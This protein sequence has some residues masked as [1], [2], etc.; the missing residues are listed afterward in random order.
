[1]KIVRI[2]IIVE[3]VCITLLSIGLVRG[4]TTIG[5]KWPSP[6]YPNLGYSNTCDGTERE[7]ANS[8]LNDWENINAVNPP[9]FHPYDPDNPNEPHI[10]IWDP[11][12]PDVRWDGRAII[13]HHD[14]WIFFVEIQ[15]NEYY[16]STYEFN[17]VRSVTG[18]ELG[19]ALG[20][21]DESASKPVLMNKY[22][23]YRYDEFGI[24]QPT[25]DEVDGINYLYGG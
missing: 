19:H 22:T 2:I 24:Y 1:M 16:T 18:H 25:Q 8:S 13:W 15:I 23:S 14:G 10:S 7:A 12:R 17:K 5:A 6:P 4:W 3:L 21:G 20:L 11:Y 9:D